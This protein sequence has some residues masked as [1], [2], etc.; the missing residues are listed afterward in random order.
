MSSSDE[1]T[2]RE[3]KPKRPPLVPEIIRLQ[4]KL[5]AWL[6]HRDKPERVLQRGRLIH[7]IVDLVCPP[8]KAKDGSESICCAS[9]N[10]LDESIKAV[11]FQHLTTHCNNLLRIFL[12]RRK[13]D[14]TAVEFAFDDELTRSA[15]DNKLTKSALVPFAHMLKIKAISDYPFNELFDYLSP[16]PAADEDV[17]AHLCVRLTYMTA[18]LMRLLLSATNKTKSQIAKII[19]EDRDTT[20]LLLKVGNKLLNSEG[21]EYY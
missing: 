19:T 16:T 20:T 18:V 21:H 2:K 11:A 5:S 10:M 4:K 9:V 3:R 8:P 13:C 15:F 7:L 12:M 14:C 6:S 17:S 1:E